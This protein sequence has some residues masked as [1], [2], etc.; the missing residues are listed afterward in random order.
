MDEALIIDLLLGA[1]HVRSGCDGFWR[2]LIHRKRGEGVKDKVLTIV[3]F[4]VWG[5]C[6]GFVL[7]TGNRLLFRLTRPDRSHQGQC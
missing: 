6:N 2:G 4:A 5:S 7:D 3:M 1:H